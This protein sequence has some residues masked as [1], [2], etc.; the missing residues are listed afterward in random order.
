MPTIAVEQLRDLSE[1][2]FQAAGASPTNA[3]RVTAAMLSANLAGHD[4]HGVQHIPHYVGAI[5][6]GVLD[7]RA[8]PAV[9]SE[10]P[11]TALVTGNWTFGHVGAAFATRLAIAKARPHHIAA[12]SLVQ[13]HHIGR[14]GE[15]AEMGLAEGMIVIILAGFGHKHPNVAPFGGR[16]ALLA[17]NPLAIGLPAGAEPGMVLDFATSAIAA[18]KVS[19][20]GAKGEQ[21]PPGILIDREGRPTTDPAALAAGGALLPFGG[22]KGF[23]L[24]LAIELLGRV[25]A[26]GEAHA[27]P[28]RGDI[29]EESG[30]LVIALD[31]ATFRPAAD[32]DAAAADLLR[33]T[34]ATPPAT[35]VDA[36]MVPGEPERRTRATREPGGI[37]L[38]AA[39]WQAIGEVAGRY[40]VPFPGDEP[41]GVPTA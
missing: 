20:A 24:A 3:A 40:R 21:L 6:Q 14:L 15:Y 18:G 41:A 35:G 33:R 10:T 25:L 38:P 30:T 23:A 4:S 32:Y 16:Q 27:V 12:V 39:T 13:S 28:G 5:E 1:A 7:P 17:T 31:P 34:R 19:V 37:P 11:A 22:H 8:E 29:Y 36:V 26:G 2:V 9:L